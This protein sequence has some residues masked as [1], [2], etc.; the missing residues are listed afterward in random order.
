MGICMSCEHDGCHEYDRRHDYD[1]CHVNRSHCHAY[2][3]YVHDNCPPTTCQNTPGIK[4]R[5]D[6]VNNTNTRCSG[7]TT[8]TTTKRVVIPPNNPY[9]AATVNPPRE[10]HYGYTPY[11]PSRIQPYT[12]T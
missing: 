7:Y 5:Q 3:A 1:G 6:Y 12:A 4:G 8:T 2:D 11:L 9:Y 10:Q